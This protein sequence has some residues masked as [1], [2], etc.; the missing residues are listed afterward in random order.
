MTK[1][2]KKDMPLNEV[3]MEN[4]KASEIL[5]EAGLACV[6]C[7]MSM[8]ETIEQ[9]CLAHGMGEKQIDELITKLNSN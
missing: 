4:E 1:K 7:P 2:I 8:Q 9:G 5:F 6:G 3:L